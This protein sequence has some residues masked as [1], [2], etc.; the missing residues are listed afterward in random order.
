MTYADTHGDEIL[1]ADL[2]ENFRA[3][4]VPDS[5]PDTSYLEQDGFQARLAEYE[6]GDF[7]FAGVVL[8]WQCECCSQWKDVGSLWGIENDGT[9]ASDDYLTRVA[10][11]L[12]EE[13]QAQAEET[14]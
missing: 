8:E 6:A 13:D 9:R 2:P 4:V 12:F 5:T 14:K 3:F 10:K 1:D 11:E 7:T